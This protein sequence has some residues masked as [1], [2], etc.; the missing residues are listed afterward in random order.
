MVIDG[1]V[2]EIEWQTLKLK[3]ISEKVLK[4]METMIH[5]TN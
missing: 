5:G 3:L 2:V 4:V 1:S